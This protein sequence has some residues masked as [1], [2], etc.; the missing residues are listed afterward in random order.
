MPLDLELQGKRVL[1]TAVPK[2]SEKLSSDCSGSLVRK[3]SQPC[4]PSGLIVR[5]CP[6]CWLKAQG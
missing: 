5:C 1:V 3:C 6:A 4:P 2:V